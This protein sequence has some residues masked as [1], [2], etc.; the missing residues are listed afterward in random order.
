[1]ARTL[2][3]TRAYLD[4]TSLRE[5]AP[6]TFIAANEGDPGDGLDLA[7]EGA[8]LARFRA[9]PV[10]MWAHNY[11][12]PP[13]GRAIDVRTE[14]TRLLADVEF[15]GN[16]PFA[17]QVEAKYRGGFLNAVSV[18]FDARQAV[19]AEGEP[20]SIGFFGPSEPV[21][22]TEWEL[23]EISAV[24]VPM[25][26][27]ALVD[28]GRAAMRVLA[29]DILDV[30]GDEDLWLPRTAIAPH[31]TPTVDEP[32]DG[33][34]AVA[35]APNEAAVLRYMHAWLNAETNA[36][37]KGSY[38]FPHHGGRAGSAANLAG[39]RNALARLPQSS[40]PDGERPGVERHLRR[41]LDDASREG[42]S[43]EAA[44]LLSGRNRERLEQVRNLIA[45]VLSDTDE[46]PEEQAQ[47]EEFY[48]L[49]LG[50]FTGPSGHA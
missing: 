8:D 22:V 28:S 31:S 14:D 7:M 44:G 27:A 17:A 26:P 43:H 34:A 33:P 38:K 10:F 32:W 5:D 41:H 6:L 46:N 2:H 4:R 37:A 30:V 12:Q 36:D 50:H 1:M 16:D 48:R 29:R 24:P 13:I 47:E 3:Y 21:R 39:V 20:V 23:M 45:E 11:R 19:N 42:G 9:N 40:I 18:G 49:I 25:D 35:A 15:D